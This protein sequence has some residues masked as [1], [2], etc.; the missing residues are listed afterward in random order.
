MIQKVYGIDFGTGSIKIYRKKDGIIMNER[1]VIATMGKNENKRAIAM[2]DEAYLMFEKSPDSISVNFPMVNGG[3]ARLSDMIMLWDYMAA[4]ITAKPKLKGARFYIAVPAD[5]NEVEKNAFKKVIQEGNSKPKSVK[6]IDKPICDAFG[7]KIDI[8]KTAGDMIVNIGA[9][10]VEISVIAGGGIV[11]S[12]LLPMGGNYFDRQILNY[13]RKEYNFVIGLRTAEELKKKIITANPSERTADVFGKNMVSGLP[14]NLTVHSEEIYPLVENVF[15]DLSTQI[16]KIL[17]HTPP[18][19]SASIENNGI[20]LTGG[21]SW[22]NELDQFV[23]DSTYMK[24]N[25]TKFAQKTVI[26]G[27]GYLIENQKLADKYA[28][29]LY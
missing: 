27:L 16:T 4:E 10:T 22:I 14:E 19:I 25:T 6:L 24:V 20:Y 17:E 15:A 9:D 29:P 11:V 2:G 13:I 1:N 7:L 28:L 12:R 3:V 23:A 21:S 18:E 5:F 26:S 8:D